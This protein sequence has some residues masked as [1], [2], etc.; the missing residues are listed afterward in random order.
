MKLSKKLILK[1]EHLWFSVFVFFIPIALLGFINFFPGDLRDY[2]SPYWK[3]REY[4]DRVISFSRY[5]F[6]SSTPDMR[7][8]GA[9]QQFSKKVFQQL[10]PDKKFKS[11][12]IDLNLTIPAE[13]YSSSN[14]KEDFESLVMWITPENYSGD[15]ENRLNLT[16]FPESHGCKDSENEPSNGPTRIKIAGKYPITLIHGSISHGD[17][18]HNYRGVS[19]LE[20][21]YC[22]GVQILFHRKY[23]QEFMKIL[24]GN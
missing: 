21:G 2:N 17:A 20:N 10:Q 14:H 12:L 16:V 1:K 13:N 19:K 4:K 24:E 6:I 22:I 3:I 11:K 8:T 5:L 7:N 18:G 9:V 15:G 23:E